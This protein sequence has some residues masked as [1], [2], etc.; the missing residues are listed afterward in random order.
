MFL[1]MGATFLVAGISDERYRST[2]LA[3]LKRVQIDQLVVWELVV[4]GA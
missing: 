3:N 4:L 1:E 2:E